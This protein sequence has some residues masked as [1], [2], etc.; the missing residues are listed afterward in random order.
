MKIQ[1]LAA[2]LLLIMLIPLPAHTLGQETENGEQVTWTFMVYMAADNTLASY[3]PDDLSEMMS[4]GSSS[5][6]NIVVLYDSTE[7]GDS[8]LYYV[9]KGNMVTIEK[10]GELDMGSQ[11]TLEFFLNW[12]LRHYNTTYYF[13]DLWDHGSFYAGVCLDHG[14]WLTL[15]EIRAALMNAESSTGKFVDVV[16]FD[17]CRMGIIE[18]FY[19]L[20]DVASFAV[21]SEKDEPATGWPYD[22]VLKRIHNVTPEEASRVVVDEMYLWASEYYQEQGL[23]ITMASVNLT[24]MDDFIHAFSSISQAVYVAPYYSEEILNASREAE[25]YELSSDMDLYDF[26]LKLSEKVDDHFLNNFTRGTMR[27]LDSMVYYR[28]WNCPNPSNGVHAIY[29]HGVGIYFP[30]YVIPAQ[31]YSVGFARDTPWPKFVNTL[32]QVSVERRSGDF[33]AVVRN[34]TLF[35]NYTV[36]A[37]YVRIYLDGAQD[38]SSGIL[39]SSGNYTFHL[40]YGRYNVYIYGYDSNNYVVWSNTTEVQRVRPVTIEG[41]FYLN[42]KIASGA[43]IVLIV[44]NRTYVAVQNPDGFSFPLTYPQDIDENS[45]FTIEVSYDLFHGEYH[46]NASSLKYNDTVYVEIR[47]ESILT[48]TL[49]AIFG[50]VGVIAVVAVALLFRK[51]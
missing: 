50:L 49:V 14:N 20:R 33:R 4:V 42:G 41:K 32:Y 1:V 34:D 51:K 47:E 12:T 17:A 8:A 21:A 27:A 7:D 6:L 45:N 19:S 3:A 5:D 16:G 31:Y 30:S 37:N 48:T 25:R 15:D 39:P 9:E 18:T 28:V 24:R 2:V 26:L 23:S 13:L 29:S 44:D 38:N 46:F 40:D 10:L 36:D 35:I 22:R 43:R 11:K